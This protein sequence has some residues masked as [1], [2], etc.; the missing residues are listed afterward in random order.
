MVVSRGKRSSFVSNTPGRLSRQKPWNDQHFQQACVGTPHGYRLK[1]S[2]GKVSSMRRSRT[3]AFRSRQVSWTRRQRLTHRR[4]RAGAAPGLL[5]RH[6]DCDLIQR[7]RQAAAILEQA[8][9]CRHGV[10][11][12]LGQPL[13]VDAAGLGL[14]ERET[15]ACR[16]DHQHVCHRGA[17]VRATLTACLRS[18]SLGA[19]E[20]P[21]GPIVAHRGEAGA[22]AGAVDRSDVSGASPLGSPRAAA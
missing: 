7:A 19:R 17:V 3:P 21:C 14:T 10:G 4:A 16:V 8:T 20:A 11:G 1:S 12:G 18:R 6:D 5:G 13:S 9:P 15:R 2:Y 22:R